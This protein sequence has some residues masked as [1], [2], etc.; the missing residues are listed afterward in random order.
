MPTTPADETRDTPMPLREHLLE[1]RHRLI[2]SLAAVFVGFAL[3]Y[4]QS[5]WLFELL[6]APLRDALNDQNG[7][8]I[9]T[10]LMEPFMVYIKTGLLGGV[11]L[12]TPVIFVQIWLFVRPAFRGNEERYATVFVLAG[13]VLFMAGSLFGYFVVFPYGFRFLIEFAGGQ[14]QPLLTLNEYFS[15]VTRLLLVFGAM[16]ETPLVLMFLARLGLIDAA[17][18]RHNRRYAILVIFLLA[19]ILTPSPDAFTQVMLALPLCLL[20]EASVVLV[21]LFGKKKLKA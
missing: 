17:W 14:F 7:Q 6:L 15:L 1:L 21:A 8:M 20:Y 2:V 5:E 18:L 16:F 19:A 4:S 9:F 3:A 11:F 10:G 12:A 13:S